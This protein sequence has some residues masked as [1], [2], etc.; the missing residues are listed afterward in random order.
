MENKG[1]DYT[2][3]LTDSFSLATVLLGSLI[4]CHHCPAAIS[5]S[6]LSLRLQQLLKILDLLLAM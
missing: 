3:I 6:C 2:S 4:S 5:W 1:I